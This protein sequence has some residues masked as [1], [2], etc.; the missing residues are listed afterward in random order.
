[1]K[2][3]YPLP[4]DTPEIS[5]VPQ[6]LLEQEA[7]AR[8]RQ[9]ANANSETH[10]R[11]YEVF[12]DL[13]SDDANLQQDEQAATEP[14]IEAQPI[15]LIEIEMLYKNRD[16]Q[17]YAVEYQESLIDP[18]TGLSEHEL[19]YYASDGEAVES[20]TPVG[21]FSQNGDQQ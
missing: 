12:D 9:I 5:V 7:E 17:A 10:A 18:D 19:M 2:T 20:E 15:E 21:D 11:S 16:T 13:D 14:E 4:S 3:S 1:M 8:A 6:E